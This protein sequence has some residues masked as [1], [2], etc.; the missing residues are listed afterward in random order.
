MPHSDDAAAQLD[1]ASIRPAPSSRHGGLLWAAAVVVSC[2]AFAIGV[3]GA[4][5]GQISL[6]ALFAELLL[7]AIGCWMTLHA[8]RVRRQMDEARLVAAERQRSGEG[9]RRLSRGSFSDQ[10]Q[11][12][13]EEYEGYDPVWAG[14]EHD[15]ML[16]RV[17][18]VLCAAAVGVFALNML[19]KGS[20]AAA[21]AGAA[22]ATA[23]GVLCL[24]V[25]CI[26]LV[27]AKS[28]A[29]L[30]DEEL[31]EAGAL[32]VAFRESQ[33]AS[34]L[35]AV[36]IFGSQFWPPVELWGARAL[37]LWTSLAAIEQIGRV[38]SRWIQG[39]PADSVYVSPLRLA[40][41]DAIFVRGNPLASV[42]D[43]LE[44]KWGL[45]FRSSWAIRF[46]RG[47]AVPVL[48]LA[49]FLLWS[50]S[51]L[52]MVGLDEMGIRQSFGRM[53]G[54]PL[55]PGLQ[56]KLPWP[57]GRVLRFP[58]KQVT[59]RPVGFAVGATQPVAY[60]WTKA[61]SKEEFALVLG[62]GTEAVAVNAMIYYKIREDRDGFLDYTLRFQNP[63][64]AIES[65]AY[66]VLMEQTRTATLKDVLSAN[67]AE[68]AGHLRESLR[69]Y[70][71]ENRLG[72][73]V[74]EV[75]LLNL[76]PPI[77]AAAD[78]LAVIS[79]KIDAE[80]FQI[81]AN[82]EKLVRLQSSEKDSSSAVATA[83]VEAARRVGLAAEESGQ[84]VALGEAFSVAPDSFKM[85][86]WF[87]TFEDILGSKP[88]VL[89]DKTFAAGPGEIL[90]DLRSSARGLEA[91][92]RDARGTK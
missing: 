7:V 75:A 30:S 86:S 78:Y 11:D 13:S 20:G 16:H 65:F 42:F 45:S 53:H 84:F 69:Q 12:D 73:D 47:A 52:S 38:V 92:P 76:H 88:L 40:V 34:I 55:G 1:S 32:A 74:V 5:T 64:A 27:F 21:A 54:E 41:R 51:S 23:L 89:I 68:F 82:A 77:E 62:N 48:A 18:L 33:W 56:W 31:P 83:K 59:C 15:R 44:S 25:S 43:T 72:I 63:D 19:W 37:L 6:R 60:L 36:A 79:A 87:E 61:H 14:V 35:V 70:A 22:T 29:S 28:F 71:R 91:I 8:R 2:A 9:S 10:H 66:R 17:F 46:V 67:R 85:R 80:R 81:E 4:R 57:F 49:V 39:D 26:W 58:V 90:L 24:A 50:L 3:Y